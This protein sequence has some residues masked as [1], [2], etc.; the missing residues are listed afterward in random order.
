MAIKLPE[1]DKLRGPGIKIM[2]LDEPADPIPLTG[3]DSIEGTFS[4]LTMAPIRVRKK[5]IR[6]P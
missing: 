6:K 3:N 2:D 5:R 4:T 1:Y